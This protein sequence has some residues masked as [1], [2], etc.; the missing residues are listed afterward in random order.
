M[1]RGSVNEQAELAVGGIRNFGDPEKATQKYRSRPVDDIV[2]GQQE[3]RHKRRKVYFKR[4]VEIT[5][6]MLARESRVPVGSRVKT[7]VTW[8]RSKRMGQL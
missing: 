6:E 1:R 7:R 5:T 2:T 4:L 3:K 8:P